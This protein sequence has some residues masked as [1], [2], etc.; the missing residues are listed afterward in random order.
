MIDLEHLKE[1]AK[2]ASDF[3]KGLASPHRLVLLCLLSEGEKSVSELQEA[4]GLLQTSVSQHLKKLK[5]EGIVDFRRDHRTLHYKIVSP[6]VQKILGILHQEFC[7]TPARKI[8]RKTTAKTKTT[9]KG[10]A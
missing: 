9:R 10:K 6:P 1:N 7:E 4:T 5:D 8:A 2:L 3:L